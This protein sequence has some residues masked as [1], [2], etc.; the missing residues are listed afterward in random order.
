MYLYLEG[1]SLN[2]EHFTASIQCLLCTYQQWQKT[3]ALMTYF[4]PQHVPDK[5]KY[6]QAKTKMTLSD[7]KKK[8]M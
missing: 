3:N 6:L 8:I 7:V 4:I 5:N 2:D 1:R